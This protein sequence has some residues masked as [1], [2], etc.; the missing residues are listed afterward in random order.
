MVVVGREV[1]LM[2]DKYLSTKLACRFGATKIIEAE[3]E[4]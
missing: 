4:M 2:D 3:C 1:T